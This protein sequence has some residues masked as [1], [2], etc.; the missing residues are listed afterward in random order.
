MAQPSP[1]DIQNVIRSSGQP[2]VVLGYNEKPPVFNSNMIGGFMHPQLIRGLG[3]Y[4]CKGS[5]SK[6]MSFTQFYIAL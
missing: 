5:V 1:T 6:R 3:F 4:N 2:S